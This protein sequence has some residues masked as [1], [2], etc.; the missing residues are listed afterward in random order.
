MGGLGIFFFGMKMMSDALQQAASDVIANA[1][2]SLTSNR[3]LAV[4]VGMLVTM[5]VQS[6]SSK[7]ARGEL[8]RLKTSSKPCGSM[9]FM[10][11]S[12]LAYQT[13]KDILHHT[14]LAASQLL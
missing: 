12:L 1:I 2:N 7:S 10:P 6:S 13:Y 9:S 3:F 14:H 11:F 5:I 4:V 8:K